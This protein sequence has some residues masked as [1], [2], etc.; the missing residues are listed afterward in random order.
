VERVDHRWRRPG[1]GM[2]KTGTFKDV[3]PANIH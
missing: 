1:S 2:L 3:A